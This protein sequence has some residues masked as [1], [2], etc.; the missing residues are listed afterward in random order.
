[1]RYFTFRLVP[2]AEE[3]FHPA[4]AEAATHPEITLEQM[5]YINLLGD[6]TGVV[7]LGGRG[8][9][10]AAVE[11]LRDNDDV[12]DWELIPGN[13]E[14]EY[15]AYIHFTDREPA[16]GLLQLL[17]DYKLVLDLPL[18][19][20]AAGDLR[21]TVVGT[22]ENMQR[23]LA[24][25]PEAIDAQATEMGTF[26]PEDDRAIARLTDRQREV[27]ETAVELGYYEVPRQATYEEI[28]DACGCT[29]GTVGEHLN[30]IE[31]RIIH[32]ALGD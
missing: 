5:Q 31:A 24:N 6:G 25:V 19:F 30:R 4:L 11:I 10:D 1:M 9:P 7:L 17:E 26:N 27:L 23:A 18:R 28:A 13:S 12:I 8:D 20:N 32:A 21:V 2:L 15:Y 3:Y 14:T 16:V 22:D 29:V